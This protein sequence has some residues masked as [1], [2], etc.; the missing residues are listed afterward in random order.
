LLAYH[1]G[2][3]PLRTRQMMLDVRRL[4]DASP[5]AATRSP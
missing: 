2:S 1:L 5:F 3:P 4:L